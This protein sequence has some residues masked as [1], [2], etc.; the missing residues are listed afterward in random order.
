MEMTVVTTPT[1]SD[2]FWKSVFLPQTLVVVGKT[3]PAK[4]G[5][6]YL[7]A[8]VNQGYSG[9]VYVVSTDGGPSM[10]YES[11]SSIEALPAGID[12]AILCVPSRE[13]SDTVRRL[14]KKGVKAAHV[15][16]SGF[17]DLE[18]DKGR[19][20]EAEL[21]C[22]AHETGVRVIGPNC[23]GVYSPAVG[24]AFPP[25]IFPKGWETSGWF[26]RAAARPRR[27]S[28]AGPTMPTVST[29]P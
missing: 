5:S 20:L 17:G 24:I 18:N 26:P 19:R 1:P 4:G 23:L 28:G 8:L 13:V 14:A 22:A 7:R 6:M 12:Y 27:S 15:F 25:G 9:K 29:R 10:D 3:S 16:S 2:L 21:R 11:C